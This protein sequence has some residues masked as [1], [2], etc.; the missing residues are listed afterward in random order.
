MNSKAVSEVVGYIFVFGIILTAVTY[1][2]LNVNHLVKETT[3][4]YRVEGI[5]ES[6][7]RVQNVFFLSV[8][9]G[10]PLQSIQVEFQGGHLY[11]ENKTTVRIEVE[12]SPIWEGDV[13]A[14][15]Y[16]LGDYK[17]VIENGAIWEDF[18]GYKRTVMNPRIFVKKVE[19][20]GASGA[21]Y[22][23]VMVVVD[24]LVG[25]VSIAGY[26]SVNLVF[27]TSVER[28]I[29]NTT[30][31]YLNFSVSSPYYEKWYD[32]FQELTGDVFRDPLTNTARM[33]VQYQ[34]LIVTVYETEV[35]A[36]EV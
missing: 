10:A 8:Y 18:Y 35:R 4:K 17:I 2:Y 11:I 36:V 31:G 9:G 6:F 23:V 21:N 15:S 32:F 22:T 30:P 5:R 20:P 1:A 29:Y 34:K 19:V 13:R 25:D 28:V 3:D 33:T 16:E 7:K 24:R 27:N 26:G 14:L 12:N